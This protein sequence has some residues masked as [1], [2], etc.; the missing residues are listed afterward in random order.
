MTAP[1]VIGLALRD[2]DAAPLALGVTFAR[3]TGAPLALVSAYVHETGLPQ[4]VP[5]IDALLLPATLAALEESAEALRDKHEVEVHA[6]RGS[7]TRVLHE[8]AERLGAGLIVVGSSHRGRLGRVLSGSVTAGVLHGAGCA[9]AVA[10]RGYTGAGSLARIAVAYDGSAESRDALSAAAV[11]AGLAG[12]KVHSYSVLEPIDRYALQA[13][14][15]FRLP[16]DYEESRRAPAER[17]VE[18]ARAVV[19]EGAL[20]EASVLVGRPAEVLVA[21]SADSDLLVSGSRGYGA[22][23]SAALGSVSH[24]L[25]NEAACP[26]LVM[27]HA[28]GH[29]W[30]GLTGRHHAAGKS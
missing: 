6:L 29:D 13:V 10:P 17:L 30:K 20:A 16:D 27:P 4:P 12:G 11:L 8:L 21:V 22:V 2:D 23:R 9:V 26:I 19:P 1:I 3:L 25:A 5:E 28:S 7:P 14:P 24:A 18:Q 15:G